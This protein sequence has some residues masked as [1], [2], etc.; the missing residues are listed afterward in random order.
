[1][2]SR[3]AL[4]VRFDLDPRRRKTSWGYE[5]YSYQR[6]RYERRNAFIH[7]R[8]AAEVAE[9]MAKLEAFDRCRE[10]G[11]QPVPETCRTLTR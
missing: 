9:L 7:P 2:R 8:R 6:D 3:T 4:L 5:F 11:D 1:V 10:R